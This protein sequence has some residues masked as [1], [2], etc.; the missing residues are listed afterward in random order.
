M[1]RGHTKRENIRFRI[2][3]WPWLCDLKIIEDNILSKE[4]HSDAVSSLSSLT[5]LKYSGQKKLSRN[6]SVQRPAGSIWPWPSELKINREHLLPMG[7]PLY[8][9]CHLEIRGQ[10][11]L[12]RYHF[13]RRPAV[14]LWLWPHELKIY[15]FYLLNSTGQNILIG[16]HLVYRPTDRPTANS[17]KTIPY[18]PFFSKGGYKNNKIGEMRVQL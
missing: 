8:Q 12:R 6:H 16:Q 5:F 7:Q 18:A 4:K 10:K 1:S 3:A 15:R 11:I 13:V 9:F 2:V 17:C 14:W